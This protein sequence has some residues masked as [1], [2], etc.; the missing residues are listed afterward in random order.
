MKGKVEIDTGSGWK[1]VERPTDA[2]DNKSTVITNPATKHMSE[3]DDINSLAEQLVS[4]DTGIRE[5][6]HTWEQSDRFL[7]R[8]AYDETGR[9][10]GKQSIFEKD[11]MR[12]AG[13]EVDPEG[14]FF[15]ILEAM[16]PEE[17]DPVKFHV[18][19]EDLADAFPDSY[20][21]LDRLVM[22]R[23]DFTSVS[24]VAW[25][26]TSRLHRKNALCDVV[27]LH[28]KE[29][30]RA[31]LEG[32]AEAEELASEAFYQKQEDYGIF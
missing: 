12:L 1:P 14:N 7:E 22:A 15:I 20:D 32:Q 5:A 24:D 23:T 19:A 13:I 17:D 30:R 11:F 28:L 3:R 26:T 16:D 27:R 8:P 10:M 18:D 2:C 6:T 21:R 29:G 25:K 31:F 4:L 9:S